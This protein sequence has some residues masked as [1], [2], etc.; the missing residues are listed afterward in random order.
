MLRLRA[1]VR[2]MKTVLNEYQPRPKHVTPRA[3]QFVAKKNLSLVI[4]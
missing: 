3:F 1:K 2:V 4:M